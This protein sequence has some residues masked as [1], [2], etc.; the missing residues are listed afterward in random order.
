MPCIV[1]NIFTLLVYQP[2]PVY[3][4]HVHIHRYSSNVS[5]R[6]NLN[7]FEFTSDLFFNASLES[8]CFKLMCKFKL[9]ARHEFCVVELFEFQGS[10]SDLLIKRHQEKLFISGILTVVIVRRDSKLYFTSEYGWQNLHELYQDITMIKKELLSIFVQKI[11]QLFYFPLE[12][13]I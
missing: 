9:N 13:C 5:F 7:A 10:K 4:P 12:A 3:C 1:Q 6:V 11:E 8:W 2:Y